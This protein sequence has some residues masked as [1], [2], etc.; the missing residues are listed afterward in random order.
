M[1]LAGVTCTGCT[2]SPTD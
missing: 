2:S 1:I